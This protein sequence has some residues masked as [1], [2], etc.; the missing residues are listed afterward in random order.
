[1][2][3]INWSNVVMANARVLVAELLER[4][5]RFAD[6]LEYAQ[7][8]IEDPD[9]ATLPS[10]LHAGRVLGRCHAAMGERV[11]SVTAFESS[12]DLS[13]L[14]HSLLSEA[15]AVRGCALATKAAGGSDHEHTT[16]KQR[17]VEVQG[18]ML[19]RGLGKLALSSP[20]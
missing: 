3:C 8:E 17:L 13:R 7:A 4:A 15:L 16:W 1:M 2:H 12:I 14:R 11:L 5:G 9:N 6:A 20:T 10:K 18:R 19:G